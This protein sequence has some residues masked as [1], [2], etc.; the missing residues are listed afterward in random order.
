MLRLL[1]GFDF[2]F[3][4][5]PVK[6]N[7]EERFYYHV[8]KKLWD[9]LSFIPFSIQILTEQCQPYFIGCFSTIQYYFE[10]WSVLFLKVFRCHDNFFCFSTSTANENWTK[11]TWRNFLN[12]FEFIKILIFVIFYVLNFYIIFNKYYQRRNIN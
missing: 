10:E 2:F 8:K 6:I 4:S 11:R 12:Y 5:R 1:L 9:K 3:C 7:R